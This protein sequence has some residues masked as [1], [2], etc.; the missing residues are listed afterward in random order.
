V[1]RGDE[2]WLAGGTLLMYGPALLWGL[3]S[4]RGPDFVAAWGPDT[5]APLGPLTEAHQLLFGAHPDRYLG[6]PLGYYFALLAVYAPY[7]L[8]ERLTGGFGAPSGTFPFGFAS[9]ERVLPALTV[10]A[11]TTTLLMA[12]GVVIATKRTTEILWGR[13]AGNIAGWL[14]LLIYP[15]AYY[16]VTSNLDVPALFWLCLACVPF[17]RVL[18]GEP[19]ST[20]RAALLAVLAGLSVGTKDQQVAWFVGVFGVVAALHIHRVGLRNAV[21]ALTTIFLTGIAA[22]GLASG[23]FVDPGRWRSHV[24]FIVGGTKYPS[25]SSFS[26]LMERNLLQFTDAVSLPMIIAAVAGV[27]IAARSNRTALLAIIP[28]V[29]LFAGI[30]APTGNSRLRFL[31]PVD[32]VIAVF[33]GAGLSYVTARSPRW[34]GTL[35]IAGVLALPFARAATLTWERVYDSRNDAATWLQDNLPPGARVAYFGPTQKLPTLPRG[36]E[37]FRPIPFVG[38]YRS[39]TYDSTEI[40]EMRQMVADARPD[41]LLIIPDHSSSEAFPWGITL[42]PEVVAGL[43]DGSLGYREVQRFKTRPLTPLGRPPLDYPAVNP[44]VRVYIRTTR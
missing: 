29:V 11:Q 19:L 28:G 32:I 1:P 35:L 12:I 38:T 24:H 13:R 40:A 44:E 31:L 36:T 5:I 41:V 33:A 42:P 9:P 34:A 27:A 7:L 25:S 39:K 4:G 30:V 14:C 15:L 3:P 18:R 8:I 17:A 20:E 16:A 23:A 6:Y 10:L 22:Y 37:I 43:E 2:W 26:A 21:P